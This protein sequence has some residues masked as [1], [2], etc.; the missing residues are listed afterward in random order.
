[1]KDIN[2][3][4]T[5]KRLKVNSKKLIPADYDAPLRLHRGQEGIQKG[6]ANQLKISAMMKYEKQIFVISKKQNQNSYG[7][8]RFA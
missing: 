5:P 2:A 3:L 8:L 1:M 7:Q 6:Y 4:Q